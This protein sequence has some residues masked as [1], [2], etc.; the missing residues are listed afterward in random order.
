MSFL[1]YIE[2][3]FDRCLAVDFEYRMDVTKTMPKKVV[4]ATYKDVFTGETWN[5]WEHD[6]QSF[7]PHFDFHNNLFITFNAVAEV[8]C[9]LTLLH[10]VPT[11]VWDCMI[12]HRRLYNGR[13]DKFNLL[14]VGQDYGY[15][16]E[17]TKEQKQEERDLIIN[18]ETYTKGQRQ[19]ILNY[20]K[21]D[22]T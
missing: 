5:F 9:W 4:C 11:N 13:K 3:N 8:G 1:K 10:G 2:N 7:H 14:S 22:V 15:L 6:R 17:L 21:K 19:R 12:E 16:D 20:N 18:N